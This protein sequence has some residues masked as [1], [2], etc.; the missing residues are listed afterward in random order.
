MTIEKIKQDKKQLENSIKDL[1]NEFEKTYGQ[2]TI[3][4]IA[5]TRW[6]GSNTAFGVVSE[7]CSNI[8]IFARQ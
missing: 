5:I 8:D 1:L 3:K 2:N 6:N 7:V 4:S